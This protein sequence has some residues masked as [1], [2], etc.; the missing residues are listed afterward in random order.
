[1]LFKVLATEDPDLTVL[2]YAPGPLDNEMQ[3]S[4]TSNLCCNRFVQKILTNEVSPELVA[5]AEVSR[6]ITK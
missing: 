4:G 6:P 3:V 5:Y 2:N 1:M